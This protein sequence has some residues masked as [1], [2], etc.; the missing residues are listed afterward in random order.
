MR[1]AA[2]TPLLF[3]PAPRHNNAR[4]S[5]A[6]ARAVLAKAPTCREIVLACLRQHPFGLTHEEIA[7]ATGIRLDTVKPRVHELGE[8]GK[9]K[10]LRRTREGAAGVHVF[11]FVASELVGL[12]EVEAWPVPREDWRARALG[13]EAKL[14]A[15]ETALARANKRLAELCQIPE[16]LREVQG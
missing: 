9:V 16:I 8:M 6:A 14:E 2:D 7:Q 15:V 10:A 12:R 11:V 5:K 1:N 3:S 4:T 13:A